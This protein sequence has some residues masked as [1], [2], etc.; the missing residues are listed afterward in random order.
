MLFKSYVYTTKL[1]LPRLLARNPKAAIINVAS[2]PQNT[3]LAKII[4]Y[5]SLRV[6]TYIFTKGLIDRYGK[7][8]DVMVILP[9]TIESGIN[10]AYY[11]GTI[12]ASTHAKAVIDA[13]G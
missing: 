13:L 1:L 12:K 7:Q 4:M 6:G 5:S 11:F 10:D 9:S 3:P 8:I 2:N